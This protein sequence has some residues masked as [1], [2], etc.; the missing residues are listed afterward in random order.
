MLEPGNLLYVRVAM[1]LSSLSAEAIRNQ[2]RALEPWPKTFTF[3]HRQGGQPVRLILGPIEA[4]DGVPITTLVEAW[5]AGL[6]PQ[7]ER[8]GATA[9]I[10][11]ARRLE[12]LRK[13]GYVG[14]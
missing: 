8:R 9:E 1:Q 5:R 14:E 3:W 2:V 10:D 6:V 11:E 12:A 4:I 7:P 13:Q